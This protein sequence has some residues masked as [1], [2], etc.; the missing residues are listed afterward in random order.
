MKVLVLDA[1][2]ERIMDNESLEKKAGV[3]IRSPSFLLLCVKWI[4][5]GDKFHQDD[6]GY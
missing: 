5:T 3:I 6:G 2:L 4:K 1:T